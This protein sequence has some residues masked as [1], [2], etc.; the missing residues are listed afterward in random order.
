MPGLVARGAAVGGLP[1]AGAGRVHRRGQ[2]VGGAAGGLVASGSGD[3]TVQVWEVES[4]RLVRTLARH[5]GAVY[6]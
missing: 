2:R 6:A 4:G 1:V 5:T 3:N